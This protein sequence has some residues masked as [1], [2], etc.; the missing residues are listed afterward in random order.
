MLRSSS[1]GPQAAGG[2]RQ[3]KQVE[4]AQ[5]LLTSAKCRPVQQIA[6]QLGES[7]VAPTCSSHEVAGTRQRNSGLSR[8]HQQELLLFRT[9][10]TG[11]VPTFNG[12]PTSCHPFSFFR[13]AWSHN[14]QDDLSH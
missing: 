14:G 6:I 13:R 9:L 5:V 2:N 11:R 1:G 3:R 10:V 8:A 4:R 7:R 12:G